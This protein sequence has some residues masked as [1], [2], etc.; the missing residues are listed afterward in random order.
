MN[1]LWRAVNL[2]E[3]M[4]G[5]VVTSRPWCGPLK[6]GLVYAGLP[7]AIVLDAH[8]APRSLL[9]LPYSS[10]LYSRHLHRAPLPS[11]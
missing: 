5:P 8:F 11:I 2:S 10:I 7:L 4:C 1:K 6:T 9:L 3:E